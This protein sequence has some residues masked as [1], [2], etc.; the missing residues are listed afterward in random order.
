MAFV[1]L[2]F[3]FIGRSIGPNAST[4]ST[5]QALLICRTLV[6]ARILNFILLLELSICIWVYRN[7]LVNSLTTK[8]LNDRS[9]CCGGRSSEGGLLETQVVTSI[10]FE[11]LKEVTLRLHPHL[12]L[13]HHLRLTGILWHH[14]RLLLYLIHLRLILHTW[15]RLL[16]HLRLSGL[17]LHH[18]RLLLWLI[19]DQLE[20]ELTCHSEPIGSFLLI[21]PFDNSKLIPLQLCIDKLTGLSM[22]SIVYI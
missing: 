11:T 13:L 8:L 17:L 15:L 22:L 14:S 2:P 4:D 21:I 6:L 7:R 1:V 10:S 18:H 3:S 9:S 16:H 20:P 19:Y 5:S 12:L